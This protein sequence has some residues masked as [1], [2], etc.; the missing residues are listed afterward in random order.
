MQTDLILGR[1]DFADAARAQENCFLLANG[2][3]GYCAATTRC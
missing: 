3:G 2:L 1:P